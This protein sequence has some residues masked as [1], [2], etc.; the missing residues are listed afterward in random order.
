MHLQF[1]GAYPEVATVVGSTLLLTQRGHSWGFWGSLTPSSFGWRKRCMCELGNSLPYYIFTHRQVSRF[2]FTR[3]LRRH[4]SSLSTKNMA[5][6]Y[7]AFALFTAC[8]ET[9]HTPNLGVWWW[10]WD[11][12]WCHHPYSCTSLCGVPPLDQLQSKH[13]DG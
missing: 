7:A 1:K 4:R 6:C 10:R 12:Q 3:C 9:N 11:G 13:T 8:E 5:S 2:R